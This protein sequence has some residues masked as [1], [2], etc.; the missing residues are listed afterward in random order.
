MEYIIEWN[1]LSLV[2]GNMGVHNYLWANYSTEI[3]KRGER[4]WH[5]KSPTG[6]LIHIVNFITDVTD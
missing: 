2:E 1:T 4:E 5:T 6:S 3:S